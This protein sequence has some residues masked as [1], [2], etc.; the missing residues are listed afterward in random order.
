MNYSFV[1][2]S[3]VFQFDFNLL[4]TQTNNKTPTNITL[5]LDSYIYTPIFTNRK[6]DLR[7]LFRVLAMK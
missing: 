4:K 3:V 6:A 5:K 1:T 2:D 7:N